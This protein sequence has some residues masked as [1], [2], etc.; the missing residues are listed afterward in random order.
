MLIT[1]FSALLAFAPAHASAPSPETMPVQERLEADA[2][3]FSAH[4]TALSAASETI[5]SGP[6]MMFRAMLVDCQAHVWELGHLILSL[7][8]ALPSDV[9]YEESIQGR[10]LSEV[11]ALNGHLEQAQRA[12]SADWAASI[13]DVMQGT[14]QVYALSQTM[15]DAT[16]L[17]DTTVVAMAD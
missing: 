15:L 11:F 10:L 4:V 8:D 17:G 9:P 2:R 3:T 6:P 12:D 5:R 13:A 1:A 16:G 14:Q 7:E